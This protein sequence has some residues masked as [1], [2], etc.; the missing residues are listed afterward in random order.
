M[1]FLLRVALNSRANELVAFYFLKQHN[2]NVTFSS[3]TN[4]KPLHLDA[5]IAIIS[6]ENQCFTF[7]T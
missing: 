6:E 4:N 2:K 3:E 1:S 5:S 7:D